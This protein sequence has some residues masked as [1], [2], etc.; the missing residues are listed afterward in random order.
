MA[1]QLNFFASNEEV[2]Q[3]AER[4]WEKMYPLVLVSECTQSPRPE[5]FGVENSA[6]LAQVLLAETCYLIPEYASGQVRM[7]D[8]AA[9]GYPL[10]RYSTEMIESSPAGMLDAETARC[11]RLYLYGSLQSSVGKTFASIVRFVRRGS[12]PYREGKGFRI[13]PGVVNRAQFLVFHASS[14]RKP[15]THW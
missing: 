3:I 11:G 7:R 8:R 13:L 6:G 10:D 1:S 14:T 2:F 12:V 15:F 4:I 5:F 9:R